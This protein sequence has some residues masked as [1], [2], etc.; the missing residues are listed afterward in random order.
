MSYYID[1]LSYS[2]AKRVPDMAR[3]F[4]I[5]TNYGDIGIDADIAAPIQ[6]AVEKALKRELRRA[7]KA[8]AGK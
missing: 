8:E 4:V 7:E 1:S 6:K 3:G 5:Q 2:L